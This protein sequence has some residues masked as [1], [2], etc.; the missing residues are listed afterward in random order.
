MKTKNLELYYDAEA[1]IL[2]IMLGVPTP[3]FFDEIE[4]DLFEGRDIKTK[5]LK[6]FK[7]FNFLKKSHNIR[8]IRLFLPANVQIN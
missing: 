5:E 1:D 8:D 4:D 2:E 7:V 3:S 6:G